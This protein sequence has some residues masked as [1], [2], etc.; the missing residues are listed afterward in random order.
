MKINT[1]I[2]AL[3]LLA[4]T[5]AAQDRSPGGIGQLYDAVGEMTKEMAEMKKIQ[6]DQPMQ[7]DQNFTRYISLTVFGVSVFM[8]ILYS[9]TVFIEHIRQRKM[10]KSREAHIQSLSKELETLKYQ[11]IV[12][13]EMIHEIASEVFM[14][15]ELLEENRTQKPEKTIRE[16]R[17]KILYSGCFVGVMIMVFVMFIAGVL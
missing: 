8:T 14:I 6:E 10:K 2:I 3:I 12:D 13:L 15:R 11:Y 16:E 4:S 17:L 7:I 1:V 5:A 9:F